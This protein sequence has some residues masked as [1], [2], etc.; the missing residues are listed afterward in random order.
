MTWADLAYQ[1]VPASKPAS[2]P[3]T[4]ISTTTSTP[5]AT[6]KTP[7]SASQQQSHQSTGGSGRF[8]K[9]NGIQSTSVVFVPL[10]KRH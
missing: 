5:I 7:V 6:K 8:K 9:M 10:T 3:T 1:A 2:K 4:A